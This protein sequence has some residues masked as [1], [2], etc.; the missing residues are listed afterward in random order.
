MVWDISM[1]F[2]GTQSRRECHEDKGDVK[3]QEGCPPSV[4]KSLGPPRLPSGLVFLGN[5]LIYPQPSSYLYLEA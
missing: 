1:G 4:M 3:E 2:Q 5:P